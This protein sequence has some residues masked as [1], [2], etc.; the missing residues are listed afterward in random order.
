MD[1]Q[2]RAYQYCLASSLNAVQADEERRGIGGVVPISGLVSL[3]SLEE[4]GN[5]VFGFVVYD[6]GHGTQ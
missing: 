1:V 2:V 3:Q 5:A 6:F 4:E